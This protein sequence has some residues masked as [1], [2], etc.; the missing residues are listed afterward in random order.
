[1]EGLPYLNRGL[2]ARS[3]IPY[4]FLCLQRVSVYKDNLLIQT[5]LQL[6]A[7]PSV[8]STHPLKLENPKKNHRIHIRLIIHILFKRV[9]IKIRWSITPFTPKSLRIIASSMEFAC[10]F[11]PVDP[12]RCSPA[13]HSS[14]IWNPVFFRDGN[15]WSTSMAGSWYHMVPCIRYISI[16]P[17]GNSKQQLGWLKGIRL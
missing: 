4:I 7:E 9:S 14:R 15:F 10:Q 6:F 8:K 12:L 11:R 3:E 13:P 5:H 17:I 2:I 16:F 1:M